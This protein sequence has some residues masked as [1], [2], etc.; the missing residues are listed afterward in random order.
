MQAVQNVA[1]RLIYKAPIYT[2]AS[3]FLREL[4]WLPIHQRVTFK[5]MCLV[6]RCVI[7][8]LPGSLDKRCLLYRP[9]RS[10]RSETAGHIVTRRFRKITMGGRAFSAWDPRIWNLLRPEIRREPNYLVFRKL[11]KTHLFAQIPV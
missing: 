5:A 10:L 2:R 6:R 11:L 3:P 9:S 4:H 8:T 7:G 1:A